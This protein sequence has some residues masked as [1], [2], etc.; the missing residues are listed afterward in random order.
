MYKGNFRIL[1]F[2]DLLATALGSSIILMM[3]LSVNHGKAAPP[4]GKARNYIYYKVYALDNP[5]ALFRV[6][7]RNGDNNTWIEGDFPENAQ[8]KHG[9][10]LGS[11]TSTVFIWGPVTESDSAGLTRN[12]YNMYSTVKNTR[13]WVIGVLYYNDRN[14]SR[15]NADAL[16][17]PVTIRQILQI[18]DSTSVIT[19]QV[20]LGNYVSF[21]CQPHAN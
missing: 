16:N 1:I 5:D 11:D 20:T 9:I 8:S 10:F 18:G 15:M 3:I 21:T 14:L 17:R 19:R 2:I 7:V 12:V 6:I 13:P 4:T